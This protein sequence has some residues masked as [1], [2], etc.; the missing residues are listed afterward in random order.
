MFNFK[1]LEV[2]NNTLP[3]SI[4]KGLNYHSRVPYGLMIN[5]FDMKISIFLF[6]DTKVTNF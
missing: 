6:V 1:Y 4:K 5:Y 2:F 3:N